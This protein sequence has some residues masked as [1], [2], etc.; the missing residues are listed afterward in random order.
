MIGMERY[1]IFESHATS[2]DNEKGI[3]SG[4]LDPCLSEM[5][6]TQAQDLG[7]YYQ[8]EN[9]PIIYCSDLQRSFRTA[10]IAFPSKKIP[11]IQDARLREWD[12]GKFNG[13]PTSELEPM[14]VAHIRHP[15]PGGES[16]LDVHKRMCDFLE[17]LTEPEVLIIGHRATYYSL[18][19]VS[20]GIS[21][22]KV[23]RA[24]WHWQRARKYYT[25]SCSRI[26]FRAKM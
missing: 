1:V 15:F 2:T 14:K 3:A 13:Y 5:G 6:K 10:E 25:S 26:G 17:T 24:A 7:W 4:C 21:F 20:K 11:I 9:I 8:A 18:E 22:E 19:H 12:Y 23:L 16:L